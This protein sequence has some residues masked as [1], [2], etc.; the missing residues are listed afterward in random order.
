M[1]VCR[2]TYILYIYIYNNNTIIIYGRVSCSCLAVTV[3][4]VSAAVVA[5]FLNNNTYIILYIYRSSRSVLNKYTCSGW[6]FLGG[7]GRIAWRVWGRIWIFKTASKTSFSCCDI[8]CKF[9]ILQILCA[10]NVFYVLYKYIMYMHGSAWALVIIYTRALVPLSQHHTHTYTF[11][12][13][14]SVDPVGGN[15]QLRKT[16][17]REK[18]AAYRV[19]IDFAK[20]ER[21]TVTICVEIFSFKNSTPI[22]SAVVGIR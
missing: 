4:I 16:T 19:C 14:Q 8:L 13:Y 22:I 18:C 9:W 2:Y 1:C 20:H 5:V 3:K 21:K 7:G 12:T 6:F 17:V 11:I 15:I 10:N